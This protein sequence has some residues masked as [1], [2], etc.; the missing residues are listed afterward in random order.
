MNKYTNIIHQKLNVN[1]TLEKLPK[2]AKFEGSSKKTNLESP[3]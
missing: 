1:K 3:H 2:V